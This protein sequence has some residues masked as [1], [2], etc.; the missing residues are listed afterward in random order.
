[1]HS[2][3]KLYIISLILVVFVHDLSAKELTHEQI[4]QSYYKSYNY[5]K[6]ANLT[7]AIKAIQLVYKQYPTSYTVNNRLAY[8]YN[9]NKQYKNA[10]SHYKKA[11]FAMPDALTPKLGL[12]SIYITTAQFDSASKIGFQVI[13]VDHY[14]YFGNLR[15]AHVLRKTKKYELSEK[16]LLNML[17]LYPSDTLY[18]TELGLLNFDE[19]DWL[20]AKT[21]MQNVLILEPENVAAKQVILAIEN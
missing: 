13:S 7:D 17:A 4:S 14:N 1:M 3:I 11:I 8:L 5:E 2:K 20:N 12:L 18:L 10:I 15:L 21:I 16:L 6:S 9:L 19:N